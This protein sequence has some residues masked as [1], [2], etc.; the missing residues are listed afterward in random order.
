MTAIPA[1]GRQRLIF[2][3]PGYNERGGIARRSRLLASGLAN[4]GW[5]VRVV[6]RT[7]H[8][9]RF[10]FTRSP[11]LVVVEAPGFGTGRLSTIL[12][13]AAA[14]PL[15]VLWGRRATAFLSIKLFST[16]T[17]AAV[18]SLLVG[19][20]FL[21]LSTESGATSE[22]A[23]LLAEK[24]VWPAT[25]RRR[26]AF[27]AG[28]RFRR[29][30]L[31]RAAF[32]VGQTADAADDLRRLVSPEQVAVI[33]TPVERVDPPPLTGHPAVAFTGRLSKA[34]DLVR[35]LDAWRAVLI[36]CPEATLCLVGDG[37]DHEPVEAELREIV[38]DD[39]LL[40]RTVS[41]TGWVADV[42]PFLRTSDVFVLPSVVE[43]MSNSLV[44]ACAWGRVVVATDLAANRAVL[45]DDYPLLFPP[46]DTESLATKLICA[47]ED[48]TARAHARNHVL[49]RAD[50]FSLDSVLLQLEQAVAS[51]ANAQRS[52][53][54]RL[55][56][57]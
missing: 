48:D 47:L 25:R 45:G 40:E 11:N 46:G 23:E 50:L 56:E 31:R 39:P 21:A 32:I 13:L 28:M 1:T 4:R 57:R 26:W 18:C 54:T 15:G 42:V 51:A 8:L 27:R 5:E 22:I 9:R 33:P 37:G 53:R 24:Q 16:S 14:L 3:S 17:A 34:K 36:R 43:G 49:K 6:S 30:F 12:F 7:R 55:A 52:R 10:R 38:A 19:R 20:P 29:S 2:F 44:E 41:F 35:L